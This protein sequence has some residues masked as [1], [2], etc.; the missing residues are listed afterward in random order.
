M[1]HGL[2]MT[3]VKRLLEPDSQERS[4]QGFQSMF[5]ANVHRRCKLVDSVFQ[6]GRCYFGFIH[7]HWITGRPSS[8]K[9]KRRAPG[10]GS[11]CG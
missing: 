2:K 6:R 5:L 9:A 1:V 4:L 11:V 3:L 8:L 10:S 7:G